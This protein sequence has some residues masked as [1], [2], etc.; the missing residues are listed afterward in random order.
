MTILWKELKRIMDLPNPLEE[1][2]KKLHSTYMLVNGVLM[3]VRELHPDINCVTIINHIEDTS[4]VLEVKTLE[5]FLPKSGMY[6]LDDGS[7][8][9]LT[10]RPKRQWLKSYS[11]N[12]YQLKTVYSKKVI[13]KSPIIGMYNKPCKSICVSPD[14]TI[15]FMG[16][17]V[18]YVK[19]GHT[20]VCTNLNYQQEI[21][22]WIK[23][24]NT[25]T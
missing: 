24:D 7:I 15:F 12:Y 13:L 5:V 18:G 25:A 19:D 3:Y 16:D 2:Q 22:D 14:K 4:E 9:Y 10:K 23:Y 11:E 6:E 8:M 20:V 17:P 1:A 21:Q